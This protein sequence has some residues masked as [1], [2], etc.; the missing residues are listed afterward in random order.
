MTEAD[1]LERLR[2]CLREYGGRRCTNVCT[3]CKDVAHWCLLAQGH[4]GPHVHICELDRL[5]EIVG[6][7]S[8]TASRVVELWARGD[9]IG[10]GA[11]AATM[12]E[13]DHAQLATEA[14]AR[15][16]AEKEKTP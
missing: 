13:L 11:A 4:E 7:M 14:A 8:V 15:A 5:R 16:A 3:N 2:D 6:K 12:R 1:D 10:M 9:L